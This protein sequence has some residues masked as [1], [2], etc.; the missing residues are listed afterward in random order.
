M[1]VR[2][3]TLSYSATVTD[4]GADTHSL[5][6]SVTRDGTAF[7]SGTVAAFPF[8]P[9]DSG[10]YR[11]AV[12]ADDGDGGSDS[13]SLEVVVSAAAVQD[14][15][16]QPG[17]SLLVVG[18]TTAA[19]D[20]GVS[21]DGSTG[22]LVVT[23]GGVVLGTF[24]PP[25]EKP[26][27]RIEVHAQGEE[28]DVQIAGSVSLP[29]WLYGGGGNDRLKG[30]AGD[31]VLVG[32]DGDD[33]L[34]GGGGR[35]LIIVGRGADRLV[36]NAGDDILIAGNTLYDAP[37]LASQLKLFKVLDVWTSDMEYDDRVAALRASPLRGEGDADEV[38][39]FDD[40]AADVLTGSAGQDWFLFQADGEG[41][42][43]VT[44]L[45]TAEI[46]D[47]LDFIDGVYVG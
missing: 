16:L 32:G 33:L 15:P 41:K 26:F 22:A 12:T 1:G 21:Q 18:G 31:D 9:T 35:D 3:Q 13:A 39:V 40:G 19:D 43:K 28:D 25:A 20:I 8:I 47:D 24:S 14:D 29:A 36:G 42:D 4:P 11:L 30:G 2:G 37:T 34:V 17:R 46:A 45:S 27:V 44:D 38:T 7:A 6:W 10:T 5:N 23:I